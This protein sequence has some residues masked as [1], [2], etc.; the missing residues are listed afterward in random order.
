MCI[1]NTFSNTVYINFKQMSQQK[2]R[3]VTGKSNMVRGM[4]PKWNDKYLDAY[5][6]AILKKIGLDKFVTAKTVGINK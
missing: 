5:I 2:C 3:N 6:A 4:L 1:A